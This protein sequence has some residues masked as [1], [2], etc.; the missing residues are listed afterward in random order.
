MVSV[1][2]VEHQVHPPVLQPD[3]IDFAALDSVFQSPQWKALQRFVV[4]YYAL[5]A[6]KS[7]EDE[8]GSVLEASAERERRR[9][10][11]RR[12]LPRTYKLG[13]LYYS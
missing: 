11:L 6:E 2:F 13:V 9:A 5:A 12:L 8:S 1:W 4:H 3:E 10:T 7:W